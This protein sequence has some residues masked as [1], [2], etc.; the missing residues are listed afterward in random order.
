MTLS[1]TLGLT[2]TSLTI[3]GS[4]GLGLGVLGVL[5]VPGSELVRSD[6]GLAVWEGAAGC[7][8]ACTALLVRR[9]LYGV[10]R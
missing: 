3:R 8:V 2:L 4:E 5:G 6:L 10:A 1:G 9:C 7:G